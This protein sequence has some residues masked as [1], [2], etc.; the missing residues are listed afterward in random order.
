[1]L[2]S[3]NTVTFQPNFRITD[4]SFTAVYGVDPA[5]NTVYMGDYDAASADNS[6]F[7]YTWA[8]NRD[9]SIGRVGQKQ[10]NVRFAKI[11]TALSVIGTNP[12]ANSVVSSAPTSFTVD[13]S[14]PYLASSVQASDF[15][16]NGIAAN[17]FTLVDGD[18]VRFDFTSSPV[19]AQ[20]LQTMAIASGAIL[21]A[22]DSSGIVA[23]SGTFRYDLTSLTVT[24][25]GLTS[26]PRQ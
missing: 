9:N 13:F 2:A 11:S 23:F 25:C 8:D 1:M 12:A 19:T 7:Y 21:R 4:T 24:R 5:I 6:G 17:S 15:A 26:L 3:G 20:G 18:T 10:A 22:S 16:V 14:E